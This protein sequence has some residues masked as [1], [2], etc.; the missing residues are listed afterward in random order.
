MTD[1][2]SRDHP[3]FDIPNDLFQQ[4]ASTE[5]APPREGSAESTDSHA[6]PQKGETEELGNEPRPAEKPRRAVNVVL[7]IVGVVALAIFCLELFLV[8]RATDAARRA[9]EAA[10][11]SAEAA[12]A[13]TV[14]A[15]KTLQTSIDASRL[16]ARAWLYVS[17]MS[18]PLSA[19]EPV[20]IVIHG[21]NSGRTAARKIEGVGIAEILEGTQQPDFVYRQG[22]PR[23]LFSGNI[24][25][26][27]NAFDFQTYVMKEGAATPVILRLTSAQ[28]QAINTG[29]ATLFTHGEISFTD[30]F[31]D[32][33]WVKYCFVYIPSGYAPKGIAH[34][35]IPDGGPCK[36]HNDMD[37]SR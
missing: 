31:A 8:Q 23:A 3:I 33:H 26:P 13:S 2:R 15:E 32:A 4:P 12:R 36:E 20:I 11:K 21:Q 24:L 17:A 9:A 6:E 34:F 10:G 14:L 7:A 37:D 30:V 29:K 19:N 5:S 28:L 35:G 1:D 16:N 25:E 27:D 22:H 18:R